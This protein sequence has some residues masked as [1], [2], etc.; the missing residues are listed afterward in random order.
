MAS[1]FEEAWQV[2]DPRVL[3]DSAV[4][5]QIRPRVRALGRSGQK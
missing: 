4:L 2:Q 5:D 3:I 1:H